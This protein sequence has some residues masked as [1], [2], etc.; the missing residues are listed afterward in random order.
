MVRQSIN[1]QMGREGGW[2]ESDTS[3][4]L[5]SALRD[6]VH[7]R[8]PMAAVSFSARLF[9]QFLSTSDQSSE[10]NPLLLVFVLFV[11]FACFRAV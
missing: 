10:N 6:G 3:E 1:E 9:E 4:S 8:C 2:A 7:L 5:C 11:S